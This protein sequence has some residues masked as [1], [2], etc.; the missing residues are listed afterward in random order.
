MQQKFLPVVALAI[1]S[2]FAI[3]CGDDDDAV[4][5]D[6]DSDIAFEDIDLND[7]GFVSAAEWADINTV[8]DVDADG[9]LDEDEFLMDDGDFD[10]FDFDD[11]DF[12][13]PI[14]W[15]DGFDDVDLDADGLLD[16]D[17]FI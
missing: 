10:D 5:I 17:E 12:V 2:M 11:D 7:D 8:W 14:E 3:G 6:D 16:A 4:L 13:S 1:A 9:L 15:A